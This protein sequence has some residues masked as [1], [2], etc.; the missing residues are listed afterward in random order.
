MSKFFV[1]K[2]N[3][4]TL[5]APIMDTISLT[6]NFSNKIMTHALLLLRVINS[7]FFFHFSSFFFFFLK[8][9]IRR[10]FERKVFSSYAINKLIV[11]GE[12]ST[13]MVPKEKKKIRKERERSKP[14]KNIIRNGCF[15]PLL[16]EHINKKYWDVGVPFHHL[17]G[18]RSS[19]AGICG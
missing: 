16:T 14:P 18:K 5:P 19:G 7:H 2:C 1:L 13:K 10:S 8:S 4:I 6:N 3:K 17:L 11:Y 12:G 9:M 15:P